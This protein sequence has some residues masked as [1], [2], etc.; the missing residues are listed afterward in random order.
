MSPVLIYFHVNQ[1][2]IKMK[3]KILIAVAALAL[4]GQASAVPFAKIWCT[5]SN[6]NLSQSLLNFNPKPPIHHHPFYINMYSITTGTETIAFYIDPE[7]NK[8]ITVKNT[9][10]KNATV[11]LRKHKKVIRRDSVLQKLQGKYDRFNVDMPNQNF[12]NQGNNHGNNSYEYD[13]DVKIGKEQPK[14]STG[15]FDCC[16]GKDAPK[17]ICYYNI[18]NIEEAYSPN[19]PEAIKQS[20][21]QQPLL[22]QQ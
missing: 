10:G 12:F 9:I 3:N 21:P 11:N 5:A 2:N 20:K 1:P 4:C 14:K 18:G 8:P 15:F 13:I 17:E 6:A 19:A 7:T 16:V 22:Q